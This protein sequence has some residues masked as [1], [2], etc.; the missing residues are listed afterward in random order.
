MQSRLV[1]ILLQKIGK[2]L[3]WIGAEPGR[4]TI[5]ERNDHRTRIYAWSGLCRAFQSSDGQRQR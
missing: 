1:Q 3:A 2:T 5:A 4:Q